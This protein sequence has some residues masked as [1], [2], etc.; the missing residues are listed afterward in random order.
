MR[1][2]YVRPPLVA[3]EPRLRRVAVSRRGT[4]LRAAA[5]TVVAGA[6]VVVLALLVATRL[7]GGGENPGVDRSPSRH[8]STQPATSATP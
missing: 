2:R 5:L 6:V 4:R 8:P 3:V 7:G 1:E